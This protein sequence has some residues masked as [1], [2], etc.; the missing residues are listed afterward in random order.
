MPESIFIWKKYYK[1]L[2]LNLLVFRFLEI[3][4]NFNTMYAYIAI[5]NLF[6]VSML[7]FDLVRF[8]NF[9]CAKVI[10]T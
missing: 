4:T 6:H 2:L 1:I 10:D 9:K 5:N 3:F 7:I 8:L